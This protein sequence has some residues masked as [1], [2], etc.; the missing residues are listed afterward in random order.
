[1]P[2]GA[3]GFA[4]INPANSNAGTVGSHGFATGFATLLN[5]GNTLSTQTLN[6]EGVAAFP[7]INLTPGTYSLGATYA[8][9]SSYDSSATTATQ[10]LVIAKGPTQLIV[11]TGTAT[12]GASTLTVEL[13]TDS[14]SSTLPT[15][16]VTLTV[17]GTNLTGTATAVVLPDGA[18]ELL[19]TYALPAGTLLST[20][21]TLAASYPGD[22]NY[23]SS[24]AASCTYT[25]TAV[26][27]ASNHL[28]P[29]A[30]AHTPLRAL[31]AG[32]SAMVFCSA[33]FLAIPARRRAWRGMLVVFFA[34]GLMGAVGCG[35]TSNSSGT[36]PRHQ[37]A[38][39]RQ[40]TGTQ[41]DK[42]LRPPSG[43][44]FMF[45]RPPASRRSL[46][47]SRVQH[48][49]PRV[50]LHPGQ[51]LLAACCR[52]VLARTTPPRRT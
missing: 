47:A 36:P 15:G 13:D 30:P 26:T 41:T 34:L 1:M 46:P 3:Y 42:R 21:N 8:G 9:D 19:V 29:S 20:A 17:N 18:D 37:P 22:N 16:A 25:P 28:Q 50:H 10:S 32:G 35:G 23:G 2:F 48:N 51:L 39:L 43:A 11:H 40:I 5:N 31:L 12:A 33:L 44:A 24:S 27:A 45:R 6:S 49:G 14:G 4:Y 52:A 38:Y 7:L